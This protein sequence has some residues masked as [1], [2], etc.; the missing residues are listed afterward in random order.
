MKLKNRIKKKIIHMKQKIQTILKK[1]IMRPLNQITRVNQTMATMSRNLLSPN[2]I[3]RINQITETITITNNPETPMNINLRRKTRKNTDKERN[4]HRVARKDND[5]LT[6]M[7]RRL[8]TDTVR[9]HLTDMVRS[10]RMDMV[11]SHHRVVKES[12][13]RINRRINRP[14]MVHTLQM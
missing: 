14:V 11:R 1:T 9:S 6:D 4:P 2:K 8:R 13:V 7:V 3:M 5:P 10:P 12:R